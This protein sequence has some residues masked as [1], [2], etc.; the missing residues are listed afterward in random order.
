MRINSIQTNIY[1]Y[2]KH[3][4]SF[5]ADLKDRVK[6]RKRTDCDTFEKTD[7]SIVE[8]DK[9]NL[10]DVEALRTVSLEWAKKGDKKSALATDFSVDFCQYKYLADDSSEAHFLG[11]TTQKD[12]FDKIDPSK[13]LGLAEVT[14]GNDE[15]SMLIGDDSYM[16]EI[17]QTIPD[18]KYKAENREYKDVGQNLI[19]YV[20]KKYSSKPLLVV[21]TQFAEPFYKKNG[22]E[23][24]PDFSM[25]IYKGNEHKE[26]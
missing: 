15:Y 20:I 4:Q 10:H 11:L 9:D 18:S 16:L 17:L 5:T 21:P 14:L 24:V 8:F 3:N 6:A 19:D 12:N 26:S 2:N 22:F 23:F 13:L 1:S 7:V 25:M